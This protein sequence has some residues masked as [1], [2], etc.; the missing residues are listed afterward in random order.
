[1]PEKPRNFIE[2]FYGILCLSLQM[3][4]LYWK[5][6]K[7][8]FLYVVEHCYIADFVLILL[9]LWPKNTLFLQKVHSFWSVWLFGIV[10]YFLIAIQWG[11]YTK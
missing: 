8:N 2:T 7:K 11:G 4:N 10:I 6:E 9:V 1:M 5:I 3:I